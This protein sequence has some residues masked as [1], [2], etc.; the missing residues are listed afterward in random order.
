MIYLEEL[1]SAKTMYL[2]WIK[3]AYIFKWFIYFFT[4]FNY[5]RR[6]I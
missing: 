1:A 6:A 2:C 3:Y 5:L 4:N